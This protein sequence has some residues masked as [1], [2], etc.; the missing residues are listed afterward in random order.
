M[1]LGEKYVI[2]GARTT[3]ACSIDTYQP[4]ALWANISSCCLYQKSKCNDEGQIPS[5]TDLGIA[6]RSCQCDLKNGFHFVKQP[7]DPCNCFSFEED[8]S[9]FYDPHKDIPRS[10]NIMLNILVL[11]YN[12]F[13]ICIS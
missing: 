1:I 10:S 11:L 6:D 12:R 3:A 2:A 7:K 5:S 8:C 13:P 4:F 9:C